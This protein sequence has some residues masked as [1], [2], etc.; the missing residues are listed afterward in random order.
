M[1]YA[2]IGTGT[3]GRTLAARLAGLGHEVRIGTRDVERTLA[4]TEPDGYGNPPFAH[5]LVDHPE[6]RLTTFAA[7]AEFAEVVVNASM[8]TASLAALTAAGAENL[9]GKLLIDVANPLDFSRGLPPTLDPV[10][11]DSLG[12]QIQRAF[13]AARVVKTLN[14]MN[15]GVMV[16]PQ[17]VPGPHDVFL[18]GED[19]IAKKETVGL[20]T[21]FGWP[22][23]RVIDLGGIGSARGLEQVLP[24]WLSLWGTL[25]H[26]D[27]NFHVRSAR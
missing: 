12:E 23:D 24:L 21:A 11:T 15:A 20:L 25:G 7:A 17:R 18:C 10:N 6:L 14:T 16:D 19:E 22:P 9:A 27:F 13:P 5:W 8:G 26:W 2:V 3:V 1:R 4:G